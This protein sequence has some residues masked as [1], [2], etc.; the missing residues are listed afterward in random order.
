MLI[1]LEVLKLALKGETEADFV[2]KWLKPLVYEFVGDRED[3]GYHTFKLLP[4]TP[5]ATIY[6]FGW[7]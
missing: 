6:E 5:I 7:E 2:S 3:N 1:L 4:V